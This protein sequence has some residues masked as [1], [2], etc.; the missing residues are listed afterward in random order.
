MFLQFE[1]HPLLAAAGS[2]FVIRVF[3][4]VSTFAFASITSFLLP[5]H[6]FGQLAT[7]LS[8]VLFASAIGE[9]GQ[10]DLA[11]R[12]IS[13][14]LAQNNQTLAQGSIDQTLS[15]SFL[16]GTIAGVIMAL[17]FGSFG[18]DPIVAICAGLITAVLSVNSTLSGIGRAQRSSFWALA[19]REIMWRAIALSILITV[20][21][22]GGSA[23]FR[24]TTIAL[25]VSLLICVCFQSLRIIPFES[26]SSLSLPILRKR[27]P[28]TYLKASLNLLLVNVAGLILVSLDVAMVGVLLGSDAA[29]QY[30]PANRVAILVIFFQVSLNLAIA[31]QLSREFARNRSDRAFDQCKSATRLAFL[32]GALMLVLIVFSQ[33]IL[34]FVFGTAT[35]TT[36]LVAVI[37]AIGH[38]GAIATGFG[39]TALVAAGHEKAVRDLMLWSI[40]LSLAALIGAAVFGNVITV[41]IVV[42]FASFVR[43]LIVARTCGALLGGRAAIV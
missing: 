43:G 23:D 27:F 35:T 42:A 8:L 6:D 32:F 5:S 34:P 16:A 2:A 28:S 18:T 11:A 4:M 29:A 19:P 10:R 3:G 22:L 14:H 37:L 33:P 7:L 20:F 1:A 15:L 12:D 9:F 39:G 26:F 21:G 36:W 31:P 13:K 41:A 17:F 25:L 24:T 30:F 38:L 40:P